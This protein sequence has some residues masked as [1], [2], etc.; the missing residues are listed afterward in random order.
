MAAS[1]QRSAGVYGAEQRVEEYRPSPA[2]FFA[3]IVAVAAVYVYFL[4]FAQ[5]GFLKA[6][7]AVTGPAGAGLK[8]IMAVMALGG[9]L[10]SAAAGRRFKLEQARSWLAGS[11]AVC[12]LA[13]GVAAMWHHVAGLVVAAALTGGG[14]GVA[15]VSLASSL[16][17]AVGGDQL[18]GCIGWGTGVAYALCNVPALFAAGA[19]GQALFGVMA[20]C[21]G[22]IAARGLDLRAPLVQAR[23][24]DYERK[25]VVAWVL[26]FLALVWLDSGAFY[27]IQH[28]EGL[29]AGTWGD[30][31]L[32]ANAFVHL[33]SAVL[34]G[35]A[36][37][38]RRVG[39]VVAVA[40]GLLLAACALID[41]SYRAFAEG[42]LLY[43]AGVSLYSSALVFYPARSA[44]PGLAAAVYGVAG[45][46]GSGLGIGMAENLREV[47]AW[48]M[49][50]AGAVV[51]SALTTRKL[52]SRNG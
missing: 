49:I 3:A 21:V 13:A 4:I 23:G 14:L 20:A 46:I 40:A 35:Y 25:G 47:P 48:F 27:I 9:V 15:T 5:F 43:T 52:L 18:G 31:R 11:L 1:H 19:R 16:R 39:W 22:M 12:A 37:D 30:G 32:Y 28:T 44:R 42:A 50:V 41:E 24:F 7:Q 10:G 2:A 33:A 38:R 45:W 36:L 8:P 17:R 26:V 6:V 29:K 34:A 51:A